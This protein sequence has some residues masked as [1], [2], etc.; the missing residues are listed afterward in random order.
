MPSLHRTHSHCLSKVTVVEVYNE[1]IY[2]LLATTQA[3]RRE[4]KKL[5]TGV[6][7][8][9]LD[10]VVE[11]SIT[12]HDEV[13]RTHATHNDDDDDDDGR[14]GGSGGSGGGVYERIIVFSD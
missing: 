13:S 7:G 14:A 2:D 5:K 8:V 3:A 10:S 9:Y 1:Q 11:R 12:Q 6:R 4:P